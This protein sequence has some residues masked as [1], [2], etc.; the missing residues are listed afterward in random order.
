MSDPTY[1]NRN[2]RAWIV[3]LLRLD[4]AETRLPG[5]VGKAN[6]VPR[7]PITCEANH[8]QVATNTCTADT[9]E[10]TWIVR[11]LRLDIAETRLPGAVG[12]ANGVP[13]LPITCKSNHV[14]VATNTCTADSG[15]RTWIVRLLRLDIAETR[16]P[17]T[18]SKANGVPQLPITCE[19]NHMGVL[20]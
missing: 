11:L 3:R 18:V 19:A 5:A 2:E 12:K 17:G 13:Q 10:R 16:L 14:Q 6:G 20:G 7:L 8:V 4:I 15:E 1:A 9:S